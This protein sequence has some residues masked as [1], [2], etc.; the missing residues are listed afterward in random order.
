[1]DDDLISFLQSHVD[2]SRFEYFHLPAR[3]ARYNPDGTPLGEVGEL[4]IAGRTFDLIVLLSVF[5]HL[6]PSDYRAML[7]LLRQY[8]A[9]DTVLFFSLYI[10]ELTDGGHGLVDGMTKAMAA[11]GT[12][13]PALDDLVDGTTGARPIEK[14]R[15]L[16]PSRPL[17]WA[18][19]SQAYARELIEGTGWRV[20]T[21]SPPDRYIQHHFV[22]T[23]C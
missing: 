11:K 4:P 22:C 18:L 8:A 17:F 2:D 16:D 19:Y 13:T 20:A 9:S 15:D 1:V 21:L 10:D 14:Y 12:H 7:V 5:T 3:N 23:P 6:D